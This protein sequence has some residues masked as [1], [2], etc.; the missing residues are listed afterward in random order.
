M[1]FSS[2]QSLV[3]QQ[4]ATQHDLGGGVGFSGVPVGCGGFESPAPGYIGPLDLAPN[5]VRAGS[6]ARHMGGGYVGPLVQGRRGTMVCDFGCDAN[7]DIDL[8]TIAGWGNG[9]SVEF[10]GSYNHIGA[11]SSRPAHQDKGWVTAAGDWLRPTPSGRPGVY[12]GDSIGPIFYHI[13]PD[14][15]TDWTFMQVG[16]VLNTTSVRYVM[17]NGSGGPVAWNDTVIGATNARWRVLGTNTANG[18]STVDWCVFSL[19]HSLATNTTLYHVNGV[20]QV[21]RVL[22]AP[23]GGNLRIAARR[24]DANGEFVAEH[25]CWHRNLITTGE[26]NNV[27]Q[28]MANYYGTSWTDV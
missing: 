19:T 26:M 11:L 7:G 1:P 15:K 3:T 22:S 13:F 24:N 25:A 14:P 9:I 2:S 18:V 4:P 5:F 28:N 20:L 12:M 27:G 23:T 6:T 21:T 17:D 16:R 10:S 8:A